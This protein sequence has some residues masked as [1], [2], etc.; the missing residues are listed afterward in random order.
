MESLGSD[1]KLVCM[2]VYKPSL[3]LRLNE[4]SKFCNCSMRLN[5][6]ND[7]LLYGLVNALKENQ[8]TL[9]QHLPD[10]ALV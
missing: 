3:P 6:K 5:L 7:M 8:D 10:Y 1:T 2:T 9:T 4:K